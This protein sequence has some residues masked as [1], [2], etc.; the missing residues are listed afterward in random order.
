MGNVIDKLMKR[1]QSRAD[2]KERMHGTYLMM[3]WNIELGNRAICMMSGAMEDECDT[4]VYPFQP[5]FY[6][7]I[8]DFSNIEICSSPENDI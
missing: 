4:L 6:N 8:E 5:I 2:H 3:L 1:M 7:E